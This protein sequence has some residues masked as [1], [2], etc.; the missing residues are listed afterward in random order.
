MGLEKKEHVTPS[1]PVQNCFVAYF[2]SASVLL[3]E[4]G[5]ITCNFLSPFSVYF[6]R[7]QILKISVCC[8]LAAYTAINIMWL[9]FL[10]LL[11]QC[12]LIKH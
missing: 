7:L 9:E 2:E 3:Y 10:H 8:L 6:L 11:A 12:Q 5:V 4:V 1:V